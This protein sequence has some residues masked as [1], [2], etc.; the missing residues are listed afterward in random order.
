MAQGLTWLNAMEDRGTGIIRMT[1]AM[2][3]HGLDQ[4]LFSLDDG[5][6]VVTLPGPND[7]LDRIRV[8][9]SKVIGLPPSSE[10]RLSSRQK[11]IA[12]LLLHGEELTS[13]YCQQ[14]YNISRQS[15]AKDFNVLIS[16]GLAKVVGAGRSARYIAAMSAESS[17]QN[18]LIVNYVLLQK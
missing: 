7:N 5:C 2:L 6:V 16:E 13:R 3:D 17:T 18:R 1:S 11:E 4:P 15:V 8:P 12:Q 10:S 9:V 14:K